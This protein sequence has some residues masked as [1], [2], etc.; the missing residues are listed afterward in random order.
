MRMS[1]RRSLVRGAGLAG[2]AAILMANLLVGHRIHS[3]E[4]PA[5]PRED[6]YESMASF[7]RVLEQVR[8]NYV[9]PGRTGFKDLTYGALRGLMASLD[10]HCE[11]M[12][13]E[14]YKAMQEDTAGRFGGI[15]VVVGVRDG[16]LTII[17][18]MEDTPGFRAGLM[19]G[20]RLVEID[21]QRTDMMDL[22][23]AVKLMRGPPGSRVKIR[24]LREGATDVR[25]LEIE[26]AIIS[27][28]SVKDAR[29]IEDGIGYLRVVQFD[30]RTASALDASLGTLEKQGARALVID[31]RNNPGGLLQAAVEVCSRFLPRGAMVV[32]TQGRDERQRQTFLVRGAP[33][34]F[35]WP[36]VVLVNEG[37]AS[38]AEIVGGALQDHKRAVLVGQ[39]TFGKG[40]VQTILPMEDGSALRL[41]T[42]KYYTP[43]RR[44]IHDYGIEPDILI[45]VPAEDWARILRAR[46]EADPVP[47]ASP[48][49]G[50]SRAAP[51][52][53][54]LDRAVDVLKGILLYRA[55]SARRTGAG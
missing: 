9:D 39:R 25:T 24:I 14:E 16:V 38:A 18:P 5:A 44:V 4:A 46:A 6:A 54:Q 17:A 20:D 3:K 11:F 10:E 55:E 8:R 45:P 50:A 2:A 30:E 1:L 29:L 36:V 22:G 40:S 53:V 21:G 41:T 52:D 27:V 48:P 47:G 35:E 51:R 49:A 12:D 31:L 19:A 23:E 34:S 13:P 7:T 43:G 26:R 32:Y 37:S 15:G 28:A 42:S 33:K